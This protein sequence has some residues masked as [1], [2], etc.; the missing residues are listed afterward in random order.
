[1]F[2]SAYLYISIQNSSFRFTQGTSGWLFGKTLVLLRWMWIKS[3]G[4]NKERTIYLWPFSQLQVHWASTLDLYYILLISYITIKIIFH[5]Q[6]EKIS[7]NFTASLRQITTNNLVKI[8][9]FSISI[10]G[11]LGVAC[12]SKVCQFQ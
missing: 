7:V 2:D 11:V 4:Q 9:F 10:T 12:L 3:T 8:F 6:E 5:I 1:M